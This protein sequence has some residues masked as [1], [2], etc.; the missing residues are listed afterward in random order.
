LPVRM[1]ALRTVNYIGIVI[2]A[3]QI[4]VAVDKQ[5]HVGEFLGDKAVD[6]ELRFIGVSADG[7]NDY[8]YG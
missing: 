2:V 7:K 1:T 3:A 6:P 8:K 4:E 5:L